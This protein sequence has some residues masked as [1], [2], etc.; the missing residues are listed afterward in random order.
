MSDEWD[1]VAPAWDTDP[2][3]R[4]YAEAAFAS[5]QRV[6]TGHLDLAG[7]RV[8]D[9]GCGTGLLTAHLVRVGAAVDAVD[10]SPTMLQILATKIAEAGWDSVQVS[11]DLA[12]ATGPYDLVVASSVLSFVDDHPATVAALAERLRPG[13]LLV[14]W[15]WERD[16]DDPDGHGLGRDQI[17]AALTAAGLVE[18]TVATAF[19]IEVEDMT[20]SPLI[21]HARRPE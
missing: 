19:T 7:A 20:M 12:D 2:G 3:P 11:G 18:P 9:F 8:L 5:L 10:T 1:D 16:G 14:H 17:A 4:E 6:L 15:D 21:G 13:G